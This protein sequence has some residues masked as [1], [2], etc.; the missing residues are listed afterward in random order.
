M[1][2]FVLIL[3]LFVPLFGFYVPQISAGEMRVFRVSDG[4]TVSFGQMIDDIKKAKL[5]FVGETHDNKL[6]HRLQLDVIRKL[7]DL[8]IP[9]AVGLEMFTAENQ[10]V[11]DQWI[12][13]ELSEDNFIKAYYANWNF[14]WPLYGDIFLYAKDNKIP[15][16]GLNIPPEI[17]QKVARSG[18]SSLTKGELEKL[19]P[20]MGC[21]VDRKYMEFIR[22]AYA[23]HGH[24]DKQFL[25]F[26][27]AQLLW[28][29]SMAQNL[30]AFIGRNPDKMVV[31]LTGNGHAWKRGIPEQI[32]MRSPKTAYRVLLPFIS[33]YIDPSEITHE[34]TD[35]ILSP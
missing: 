12:R 4:K 19:P 17:S 22:R 31:V 30:L 7:H 32:L 35:Y 20:E 18:F 26:C 13:G 34:D 6:H 11:L 29:Q 21:A 1:K 27:E 23:M 24:R 15:L 14:P 16:I 5:I 3:S 8:K 2:K 9:I 10:D 28:D 33:G 25:Y